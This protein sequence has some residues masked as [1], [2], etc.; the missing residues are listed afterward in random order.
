[1]HQ[2][3]SVG[4]REE[5]KEEIII[6][7]KSFLQ[8]SA[9]ATHH[10]HLHLHSGWTLYFTNSWLDLVPVPV[11][12]SQLQH[13]HVSSRTCQSFV[14]AQ[15]L[16]WWHNQRETGQRSRGEE[17]ESG[18]SKAYSYRQCTFSFSSNRSSRTHVP[19]LLRLDIGLIKRKLL[20]SIRFNMAEQKWQRSHQELHYQLATRTGSQGRQHTSYDDGD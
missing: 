8:A 12:H 14:C 6:Q 7:S 9:P 1:M 13:T 5:L 20:R 3:A 11:P 2:W 15:N 19:R 4:G 16:C 17:D 10:H 18:A